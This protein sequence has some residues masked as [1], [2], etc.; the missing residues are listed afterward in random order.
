MTV[1]GE[2]LVA[3]R[4]DGTAQFRCCGIPMR[5]DFT[6]GTLGCDICGSKLSLGEATQ[7]LE[8]A[9]AGVSTLREL[10]QSEIEM[11]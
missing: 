9:Q 6:A 11:A 8:A 10:L 4:R 2:M 5:E 1:V 3:I 7:W